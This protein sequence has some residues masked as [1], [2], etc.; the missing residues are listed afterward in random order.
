[1]TDCLVVGAGLNGLLVA[2]ELAQAGARVTV[3]ERGQF[4]RE[5]SWAGGG[6]LSPLYPWRY[7]DAVTELVEWSQRCWPGLCAELEDSTGIACEWT[8][9]GLLLL[10]V[11]D[12][13]SAC[14]WAKARSIP[15]AAIAAADLSRLEPKLAPSDV[16][17]LWLEHVAQ[18][19]NPRVL[20]ALLQD[21]TQRGVRLI[22]ATEASNLLVESDRVV[23]VRANDHDFRAEHVIITAGAW[24]SALL[25]DMA[26]QVHIEPVRGQM[27]LLR[28][29][30]G[31]LKHVVLRDGY[32][33]IPRRDGRVLVGSTLEYVGF[34]RTPT[35]AARAEL[36]ARALALVPDLRRAEVEMHWAGLRPGT[37]HGIPYIDRV[38]PFENL[39]LNAGHFRNGVV[40]APAAAR[41]TA[42]LILGRASVVNPAPYRI[43]SLIH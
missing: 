40:M 8:R 33:L 18:L 28:G 12:E 22:A 23:G 10:A 38:A 37:A 1:M 20:R 11:D 35:V 30:P 5:A 32:Y 17:G 31:L 43:A 15:L 36:H 41:L 42:D 3:L 26:P 27:L 29:E 16:S 24:T 25:G 21:L 19:R 6:I 14:V 34:D 7:A 2:R 39:W 4:G 13:A 9:S